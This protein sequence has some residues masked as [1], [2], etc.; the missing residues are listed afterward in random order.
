[1]E[2][3]RDPNCTPVIFSISLE[4]VEIIGDGSCFFAAADMKD[5]AAFAVDAAEFAA[6]LRAV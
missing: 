2:A 6:A 3:W 5:Y 1:M 4:I